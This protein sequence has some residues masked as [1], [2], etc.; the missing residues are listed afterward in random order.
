[1]AELL[2]QGHGSFRICTAAG[3]VIYVDPFAGDG[4]DRAA[5]LVL[6]THEHYDHNQVDLVTLKDGG[7]ILRA[8]DFLQNGEYTSRTECGAEISSVAAYNKNHPKDQCVGFLVKVDGRLLYL[9]GDTSETEEM[10]TILAKEPID[11][12]FLPMD[13]VYNMGREEAERCAAI[14]GAAHTVPVHMKPGALVDEET[15][16]AFTAEGKV[17]MRPGDTLTW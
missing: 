4:Y 3:A 12:A 13:G 6:V 16:E 7:K 2:Y 9:A 1:M 17:I 5:D 14:I 8:A 15:A 10:G 11:Y